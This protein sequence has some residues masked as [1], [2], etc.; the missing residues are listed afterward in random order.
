[1]LSS[2]WRHSFLLYNFI[3]IICEEITYYS[4]IFIYLEV[5]DYSPNEAAKATS[6]YYLSCYGSG[7]REQLSWVILTQGLSW[8]YTQDGLEDLFSGWLTH[9][10]M[11][12]TL[13]SSRSMYLLL[14]F[15]RRVTGCSTA[16]STYQQLGCRESTFVWV[17]TSLF[18]SL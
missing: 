18:F 1:M 15:V 8:G 10:V 11:V 13:V 6:F 16:S 17:V 12:I 2:L 14:I 4:I 3:K 7:I 9:M 5:T